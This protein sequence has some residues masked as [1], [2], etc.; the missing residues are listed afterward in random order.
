[1]SWVN[2]GSILLTEQWKPFPIVISNSELFR[3]THNVDRG[4][5]SYCYLSQVFL[6]PQP[7]G[8]LDQWKRLYPSPDPYFFTLPYPDTFIPLGFTVYRLEAKLRIPYLDRIPWEIMI[9][10]YQA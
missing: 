2:L 10:A 5:V 3:V 9:E 1:M 7:G 4:L 8:R 6:T